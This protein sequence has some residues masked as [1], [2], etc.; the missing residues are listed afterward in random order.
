MKWTV[1][2]FARMTGVSVRTLHHYDAI[3][4]LKPDVVDPQNGYRY[5]AEASVERMQAILFYRELDFPLV[6]I[7]DMLS[8]P[9]YDKRE[10][11][12]QQ[13]RLLQLKKQRLE[14]MLSQLEYIEK[15]EN[16]M[17]FTAFD[18]RGI[19]AYKEEAKR[20]WGDT[21]AY[22]EHEAK[23]AAYTADAWEAV[24]EEMETLLAAFASAKAAGDSPDGDRV[25]T[26]VR[27]LQQFI[28]DTQ[29]TCT[30]AMLA[31]LGQMYVADERFTANIDRHGD[32]T[33]A[34]ISRAIAA[35]VG[36]G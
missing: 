7:R 29:Y 5:Y 11:V 35:V 33:A 22:R 36:R 28:S 21:A 16:A 19:D 6:T 1:S 25:A 32:G 34:F 10:A 13:K 31:S 15:G 18:H 26:L 2:E 27:R 24:A 8:S 9:L 20:R 17:D 3:G 23:T 4:L 30:D 12:A 14:S